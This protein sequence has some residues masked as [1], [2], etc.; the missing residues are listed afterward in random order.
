MSAETPASGGHTGPSVHGSEKDAGVPDISTVPEGLCPLD[1]VA[2]ADLLDAV[3][4]DQR[5]R[6]QRGDRVPASAYLERYPALRAQEEA[7]AV[8]VYQEF[9]LRT[10]AGE[11][12]PFAG[13][14]RRFPEYAEPLQILYEADHLPGGLAFQPAP[15]RLPFRFGDYELLEEIARGGMG[16]VYRAR[17]V[18]LDRVVALKMIVG[19]ELASPADVQRFRNEAQAAAGLRH[20]NIVAIHEV[21]EH[22]GR[23]YFSMDYVAGPT[24]A[25]VVRAHPLPAERAAGYVR[26][27]AQAVQ[28]AHDRNILHRDLKPANVLIDADDRPRVTDFGLARRVEGDRRLT[29]TGQ[30]LGTPAYMP[31][32]Q[33]SG[34]HGAVGP[35]SDVYALGAVL[36]E[37]VTGRPPFQAETP[38]DT[39]L[40]VLE[41]EPVPPRML[42]PGVPGDLETVCLKCLH[43]EPRRRYPSAAALADDLGRFLRKEPVLAR[44]VGRASTGSGAGAVRIRGWLAWR[45]PWL[46][47]SWPAPW[48]WCGS[49][50]GRRARRPR[51]ATSATLPGRKSSVPTPTPAVPMMP[52]GR[53]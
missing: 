37:L 22:E 2:P 6:W 40:Q 18:S 34:K 25:E 45:R 48:R 52:W 5:A 13:Y 51:P 8:L 31:P 9:I 47:F 23:H 12:I 16:V 32:E 46:W 44:P 42:N 4:D 38:L 19:G 35:A 27:V 1:E 33:A 11:S 30:V 49:G 3:L 43:K 39:L 21:G 28:H 20:P 29:G 36:Y 26:A 41:S 53:C 10:G 17:Q 15:A 24:L 14:F 50:A 7:A